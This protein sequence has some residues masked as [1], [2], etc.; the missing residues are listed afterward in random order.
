M[1]VAKST[2]VKEKAAAK[3]TMSFIG[4]CL[5]A[6]AG[7]TTNRVGSLNWTANHKP[8]S[9]FFEK[10]A[11]IF[12]NDD[13]TVADCENVFTDSAFTPIKK[14]GTAFWFRSASK[15]ASVFQS[16]NVDIVSVANNHT[17][18]YGKGGFS[19]TIK[20]LE[21][22]GVKAG[23][24]NTPVLVEKF[25]IRIGIICCGLWRY[26]HYRR[27]VDQM[28][29]IESE[30][31]IQIVFFHGG[32]EKIHQPE[33]WKVSAAHKIVDA[34]ADLVVGGHPHV[35]QPMEIY[36]D[37]PI[38][39]SVGNFVFGGNRMPE[40]RTVIFQAS[41]EVKAGKIRVLSD[42]IPC[43][44]YTGKTNNWQ[45]DRIVNKTEK[46]RVLDFMKGRRKLPY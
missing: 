15:N 34:G 45:P 20:A 44:V 33:A 43:Y 37:V 30:T 32:Q 6:T 8:S 27:I 16:G 36:H 9:Y 26:N 1:I 40:N 19:D 5:I 10:V 25:G 11:S 2:P 7:G 39:Y 4:D 14:G 41:F 12:S 18:D 17:G 21:S 42:I 24:D 46:I 29:K 35:L 3:I 38:V 31:D 22:A 13:F 28:K 23:Y